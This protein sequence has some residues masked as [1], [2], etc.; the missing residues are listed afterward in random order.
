[1]ALDQ[2]LISVELAGTNQEAALDRLQRAV[3]KAFLSKEGVKERDHVRRV[4]D[5]SMQEQR[6]AVIIPDWFG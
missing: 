2:I 5:V 4:L 1:M 3:K 6:L